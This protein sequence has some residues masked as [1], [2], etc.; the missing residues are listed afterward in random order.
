M[1][2]GTL[3]GARHAHVPSK[4]GI[5][6][7]TPTHCISVSLCT[8]PGALSLDIIIIIRTYPGALHHGV[9]NHPVPPSLISKGQWPRN[10][11]PA[12]PLEYG[13]VSRHP[14]WYA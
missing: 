14:N 1:I 2:V 13:T 5:R 11:P 4:P 6:R 9:I 7:P 3:P 8:R 12:P 10:G